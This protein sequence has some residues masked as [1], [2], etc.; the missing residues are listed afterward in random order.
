MGAFGSMGAVGF[1]LGPFAGLQLRGAY[2][3]NAAWYFS[4]R[5]RARRRRDRPR[6][7]SCALEAAGNA[8]RG[9]VL[10]A[11]VSWRDN[12][13]GAIP[14]RAE[15]SGFASGRRVR[16]RSTSASATRVT[17]SR[18]EERGLRRRPACEP[19]RGLP[20]R[21]RRRQALPDP[22][23]RFQPQ[24]NDGPSRIV[25]LPGAVR[26]GL[27]LEELVVY[28]LHVGTFSPEG[29]F[30]G[31][32]PFLPELRELGVTAVELMPVA[33]FPGS[34]VGATTV[35]T[36]TRRIPP[37]AGLTRSCGWS[38]RPIARGWA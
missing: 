4:R 20:L 18:R 34:G 28:E 1:A 10:T 22:C 16:A 6:G 38:R 13:L 37:T 8:R 2:G 25:E 32:V 11:A 27:A 21:P 19:G 5:R 26:R 36:R 15:T 30:D 24:G 12:R 23:S 35:S 3:D 31:V 14:S 33:T 7:R 9:R 29:T 17:H